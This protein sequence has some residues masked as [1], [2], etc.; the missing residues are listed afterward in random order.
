MIRNHCKKAISF[1]L[2]VVKHK[3]HGI[4]SIIG[5]QALWPMKLSVENVWWGFRSLSWI[6]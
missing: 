2:F 1:H 6:I 3:S 5:V 4:V